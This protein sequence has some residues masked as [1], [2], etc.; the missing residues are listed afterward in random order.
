MVMFKCPECGSEIN[1][2]INSCPNCGYPI[3]YH[4]QNTG[5]NNSRDSEKIGLAVASMVLGI[6]SLLL[7]CVAIGYV[8]A[9]IGLILG[10]VSLSQNYGG[11]GMAIAGVTTSSI[12]LAFLIVGLFWIMI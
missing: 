6:L 4:P 2:N 5:D 3:Q 1:E 11:K 8:L 7:V 12:T 9:V 10:I